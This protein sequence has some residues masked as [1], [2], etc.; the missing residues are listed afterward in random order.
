[1]MYN[2]YIYIYITTIGTVRTYFHSVSLSFVIF[3]I[4]IEFIL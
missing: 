4:Y 3:L 2:V 1:M